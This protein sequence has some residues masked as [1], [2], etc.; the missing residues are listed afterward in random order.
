MPGRL[1]LHPALTSAAL[2]PHAHQS[3]QSSDLSEQS[4]AL[5]LAATGATLL[6]CLEVVGS[7]FG[8]SE[9]NSSRRS[10]SYAGVALCFV[11]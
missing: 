2:A 11:A 9:P 3:L 5:H 7:A 8:V 1:A 6:D 4:R 10:R